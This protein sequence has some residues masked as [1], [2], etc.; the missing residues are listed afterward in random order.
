MVLSLT[1]K[2][3]DFAATEGEDK[4]ASL[5]HLIEQMLDLGSRHLAVI[6]VIEIAVDAP[7]VAAIGQVELNTERDVPG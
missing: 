7:L 5:G 1:L 6:I 2:Q 4:D 3:E